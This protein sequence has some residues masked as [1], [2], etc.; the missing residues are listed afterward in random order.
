[1]QGGSVFF[2]YRTR[3]CCTVWFDASARGF[4]TSRRKP[5]TRKNRDTTDAARVDRAIELKRPRQRADVRSRPGHRF[6]QTP[7]LPQP[8]PAEP[9]PKAKLCNSSTP[10]SSPNSPLS[11]PVRSQTGGPVRST[12]IVPSKGSDPGSVTASCSVATAFPTP[13]MWAT[14]SLAGQGQHSLTMTMAA[15]LPMHRPGSPHH[16]GGHRRV[17]GLVSHR[18]PNLLQQW[19]GFSL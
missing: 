5:R 13:S 18:L 19:W 12:S 2:R 10:P 1:M 7:T 14:G 17:N 4:P 9:K 8:A 16:G 11:R 3:T 15:S 6:L